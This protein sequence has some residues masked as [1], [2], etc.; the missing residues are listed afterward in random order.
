[1]S[2]LDI[3]QKL[4]D[5]GL[6]NYIDIFSKNHLFDE[7]V[8]S[9]MTNEDFAAILNDCEKNQRTDLINIILKQAF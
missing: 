3:K 1:M 2:E 5:N 8:L 9:E 6:E 4:I 7:R